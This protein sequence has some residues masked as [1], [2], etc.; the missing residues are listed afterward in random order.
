MSNKKKQVLIGIVILVSN[1]FFN[2]FTWILFFDADGFLEQKHKTLFLFFNAFIST[3][4]LV[5]IFSKSTF[6]IKK[7]V[8][9]I[10]YIVYLILFFELLSWFTINVILFNDDAIKDRVDFALG[11]LEKSSEH[12]SYITA[13]LRTDY[14]LNKFSSKVNNLGFRHG[15]HNNNEHTYKIM[16]IGGSTTFGSGVEDSV[17]TFPY[18]L[19]LFMRKNRFDVHV[20]NSGIPYH[21]S[22]DVLIKLITNGIY[23]KPDMVL[24]HTGGNDTGPLNSPNHYLPDYTHWRDV[25][26]FNK[27]KIFKNVWNFVPLSTIRLFLIFY[28]KPGTGTKSSNQFS[29]PKNELVSMTDINRSRTVGLENYFSNIIYISKLN[30]IEPV[31]ILFNN[32]Q[33]RKGSLAYK[34]FD[35]EKLDFAI[36]KKRKSVKLHNSIM[37]S[38]SRANKV[39]VIPFDKFVPSSDDY[40]IDHCHLEKRGNEE[41]AT[42]IGN[43]L[44]KNFRFPSLSK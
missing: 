21:T 40:W 5:L 6:N 22:L 24:I 8:S 7:Y 13:D 29:F 43:Y 38:I 42:Y 33:N 16:C 28:L 27:D 11:N 32:D 10:F 12:I 14:K 37:D 2:S 18:Q 19:E 35:N 23:F 1:I 3:I 31:T 4:G 9:K 30:D 36:E 25:S 20:I 41:K 34:Y 17:D 26:S 44:I 39:N 15:G